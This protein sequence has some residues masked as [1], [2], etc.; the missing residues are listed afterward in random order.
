MKASIFNKIEIRILCVY[1]K[2]KLRKLQKKYGFN[3][4]HLIP[5]KA[6]PY[7]EDIIKYICNNSASE[8]GGIIECGCGLCDILADKRLCRFE[9]TGVEKRE[10]VYLAA[11]E[12]YDNKGI[13]FI[14]GSFDEIKGY[15]I[16]YFIA[17]NFVHEIEDSMMKRF[18][19]S[20]DKRNKIHYLIV[21]EVTG[22]YAYSHNF[23]GLVPQGYC[24]IAE[25]GPYPA[26]GGQRRIKI[27]EN[28]GV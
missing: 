3:N 5:K 16:E 11:R 14:N 23:S 2:F 8:R 28:T 12:L 20:V 19:E 17:V 26:D 9:R 21:D 15:E 4:W 24:I 1:R 25:L 7:I 6:K 27:F 22:N 13:K 10:N 18:L